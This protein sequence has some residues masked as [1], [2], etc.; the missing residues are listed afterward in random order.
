MKYKAYKKLTAVVFETLCPVCD[1]G[2]MSTDRPVCSCCGTSFSQKALDELSA[3][4]AFNL[5]KSIASIKAR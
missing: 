3:Q 4:L 1:S 2:Y 5:L